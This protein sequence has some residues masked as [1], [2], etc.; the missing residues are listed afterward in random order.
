MHYWHQIFL[1]SQTIG[2]SRNKVSNPYCQK[3]SEIKG[4]IEP[5]L[6]S[7]IQ[8]QAY[9]VLKTVRF[10]WT[11]PEQYLL[12]N[13][14]RNE[15]GTIEKHVLLH[16]ETTTLNLAKISEKQATIN[17]VIDDFKKISQP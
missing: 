3:E 17:A 1:G 5:S 10:G 14:D 6:T 16:V 12:A 9:P 8:E 7:Q 13:M 4:D 2:Y 15:K 11:T